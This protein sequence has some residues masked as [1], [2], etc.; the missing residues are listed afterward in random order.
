MTDCPTVLVLLWLP[1]L[2][3]ARPTLPADGGTTTS[4]SSTGAG[5]ESTGGGESSE[6]GE[7]SGESTEATTSDF[8][9]ESDV[10]EDE[11]EC[12]NF[13]QDCPEGEKCVPYAST[14]GSW[15]ANKCVLVL[16]EQAPGEP[17]HYG[18]AVEATD[19]CDATSFCWDLMD[20]DGEAIGTCTPFCLGTG[21]DPQCPE[22]P[23]CVDYHC[24]IASDSSVN[25]CLLTC[26][27]LAQD[28]GAGLACYWNNNGFFSCSSTA[29][30]HPIGEVCGFINDCVD[31]SGCAASEL[32][33]ACAGAYCCTP[34]CDPAALVDPCPGLLAGTSCVLFEEPQPGDCHVGRCLAPP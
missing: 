29:G 2:G 3:C 21:D 11:E 15:D 20:V 12:D 9:P 25:P 28:C 6:S 33:P 22:F 23:G 10:L 26:D 13:G 19:D 4:Q 24:Q 7:S 1:L 34:F 16:G 30:N 14:G 27:P 32:L 5:S 17:C 8:V 18:G 31:G